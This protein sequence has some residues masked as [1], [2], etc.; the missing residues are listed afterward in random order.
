MTLNSTVTICRVLARHQDGL[1][2]KALMELSGVGY[3]EIKQAME[4]GYVYNSAAQYPATINL[5]LK[6]KTAKWLP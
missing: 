2:I 4:Q 6:G 1:R 3:G 5:T